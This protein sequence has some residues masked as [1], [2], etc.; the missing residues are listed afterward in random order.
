MEAG[1]P[2]EV[3][4]DLLECGVRAVVLTKAEAGASVRTVDGVTVDVPVPRR[5][6]PVVDTMGAGDAALASLVCGV[7]EYGADLTD[8][9]WG[10]LLTRA[11]NTAADVC[12]TKGGSLA[13]GRHRKEHR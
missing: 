4:D 13:A 11:M 7:A 8:D 10:E 1:T 9:R 2:E 5:P 6:E 12:R 3:I